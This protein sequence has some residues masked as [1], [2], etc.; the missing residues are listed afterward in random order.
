MSPQKTE[1][2]TEQQNLLWGNPAWWFLWE[3]GGNE[4]ILRP[5]LGLTK[6]PNICQESEPCRSKCVLKD[7]IQMSKF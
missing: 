6:E 7:K 2:S 4:R 1:Y 3:F 5:R